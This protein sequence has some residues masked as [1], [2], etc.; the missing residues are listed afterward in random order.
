MS[1]LIYTRFI[2]LIIDHFVSCNKSIPRRSDVELHSKCQESPLTKLMNTVDGKFKFAME[3]PDTMI[4]DTIKHSE[5]YKYYKHKKIESEKAKVA[6]E[7]EEQH[8]SPVKSGRG[9]G[10]MRLGDQEV[11]VPSSFK[12]NV[13][14]KKTRSLTVAD[15][16]VEEPVAVE[17]A[18]SISIEDQRC[19]QREIMTQLTIDR[20]IEKDVEDTYAE[21]GQKLKGLIIEDPVVQSLL[22][23]R[24]GSKE[25]RLESLRQEKQLVGGE[26]SS[27]THDKQYEFKDI[28]ATN[29]D[30]TQDSLCS[31]TD[32]AKYYETDDSDMDL[33]DD[34]PKGD[35]D[36][37]GFRVFMYNKSTELLKSTYLSPTVTTSSLEYIQNLLNEPPVNELTDFISHTMYTDD[38]TTSVVANLEGNPEVTSYISG[39]SKVP[40]GTHVDVQATNIVLHDMFLNEA[41]HHISSPPANTTHYPV[42]NP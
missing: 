13:V 1:K 27:A 39:A 41:A 23:L 42:T 37:V 6:E 31:D 9:K 2:K 12:K 26:G 15:N 24:K 29:S 25:S 30:A 38:H 5:G 22:D 36:A 34:E 21:W 28:S 18:K 20:Q 3:I 16:I 17:L 33:Y 7:P 14:P 4:N 32:E 10:N 8:I 35:D 40:F 11:N 19:Q